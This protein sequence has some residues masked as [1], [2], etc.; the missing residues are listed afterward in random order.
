MRSPIKALAAFAS[1]AIA[2]NLTAQSTK[3]RKA[4][5]DELAKTQ[6]QVEET[7]KDPRA[8]ARLARLLFETGEFAKARKI[9][10]QLCQNEAQRPLVELAAKLAYLLGDY[11]RAATLYKRVIDAQG[12]DPRA[13]IMAKIGLAFALYQR[14]DFEPARDI[15]LPKGVKLPTITLM[16]SFDKRP[17]RIAWPNEERAVRLPWLRKNPLPLMR[18][19]VADEVVDVV[20]DTGADTLILDPRV[21]KKLDVEIVASAMGAFGGGKKQMVEFARVSEINVGGVSLV[22]VPIT[23]L[24]CGRFSKLYGSDDVRVGGILGTGVLRQFLSTIDYAR[25]QL[26]L[27]ERKPASTRA[28]RESIKGRLAAEVPFALDL[29]H[30]MLARGALN[31]RSGLTFFVDSGLASKACF[32]APP[33]TLEYVGIEIPEKKTSEASVGGGGGKFASGSFDIATIRLG[34]LEMRGAKGQFGALTPASYWARGYIQDGLI[35]HGF[36]RRYS[37]WTIDFD[38]MT[39]LFEK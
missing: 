17:Y 8:L 39:F 30:M 32:A 28:L 4:L 26:I 12:S 13:R 11:D 38:A 2:M 33:Q 18:I 29:T 24:P 7:P 36:L 16:R 25:S 5:N 34:K 20:L 19:K 9:A 10:E 15:A 14:N 35:S 23:I 27:R 1:L 22:D 3:T 37:S 31:G 6:A 21:T